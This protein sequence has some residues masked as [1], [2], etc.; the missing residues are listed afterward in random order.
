MADTNNKLGDYLILEK[1]AQGGMAQIYKAKTADP[2]GTERL[3]VIKRILPHISSH[4]EYVEMLIDEAKIAV[5][6]NHGNVA[7]VYDLGKVGDDYFIVMEYVDGKTLAQILKNLQERGE[8]VP[9]NIIVACFIELCQGLHYIHEKKD[10]KGVPLGV[11]HRDISPQNI[12]VSYGGTVKIIDFGVA[13]ADDKLSQTE[14]GVLKGK[15]AYMSPEQALGKKIDKQSDIFSAGT[16]L[17]E[18]LTGQR[19]FKRKTN[20]ETVKAVCKGKFLKPSNH[21]PEIP[22]ALEKIVL[23][24]LRRW[25]RWRYKDALEMAQD[26]NRFL[27]GFD[28][29]FRPIQITQFLLQ[30]FGPEPDE[31]NLPPELP[32]F[33]VAMKPPQPKTTMHEETTLVETIKEKRLIGWTKKHLK[34]LTFSVLTLSLL[35]TFFVWKIILPAL[36]EVT[37]ILELTPPDATLIVDGNPL[38]PKDNQWIIHSPKAHDFKVLAQKE[39]YTSYETTIPIEKGQKKILPIILKEIPPE[40]SLQLTSNPPGATIHI[41]L[42]SGEKT[43]TEKTPTLIPHLPS[44]QDIFIQIVLEGYQ[45]ETKKIRFSRGAQET[46]NFDLK[47]KPTI[48]TIET[49]PPGA[50]VT[51]AGEIKG[52]TPLSL[53]NITP[54]QNLPFTLV[55]EGYGPLS[56]EVILK[57][58]EAKK[59]LLDLT[60]LNTIPGYE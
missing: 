36:N 18:L 47:I 27:V 28:P 32:E 58:G 22:K 51:M 37:L 10:S 56:Q 9:I 23:K 6:F 17:W 2:Q 60:P 50:T 25:K 7:Q 35:V 11:V 34:L 8:K 14:S 31:K 44:D 3:V 38:V 13:K 52:I 4:P 26:L 59:I 57:P 24:A 30:Y 12:I 33:A 40:G 54:N 53:E 48:L 55:L 41:V 45:E 16:L 1:I 42:P 5:H 19:L 39:N 29:E 20:P 49:N 43:W 46:M 15:Y 21:R